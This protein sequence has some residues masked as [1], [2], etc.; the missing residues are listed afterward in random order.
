MKKI[1]TKK[2][3]L[4]LALSV[5]MPASQAYAALMP[6]AVPGDSRPWRLDNL[7]LEPSFGGMTASDLSSQVVEM[8][9]PAVSDGPVSGVLNP[10]L[11]ANS[12]ADLATL[13]SSVQD[14][15]MMEKAADEA[16]LVS[17]TP[18]HQFWTLGRLMAAGI[19]ASVMLA[20]FFVLMAGSGHGAGAGAGS[21]FGGGGFGYPGGPGGN[22]TLPPTI[23]GPGGDTGPVFVPNT[24]LPGYNTGSDNPLFGKGPTDSSQEDHGRDD[25]PSIPHNPE[26]M[27]IFLVALGLLIPMLRKK[28]V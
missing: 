14:D 13:E 5:M 17:G 11:P 15:L 7:A 24:N 20:V 18:Q 6:L 1:D 10:D 16:G 9:V 21:G 3:L 28:I 19:L 8:P 23:P 25:D 12:P 2:L 22:P 26:P 27:P 4:V